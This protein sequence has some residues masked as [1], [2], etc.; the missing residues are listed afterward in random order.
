MNQNEVK[1]LQLVNLMGTN[2]AVELLDLAAIVKGSS[3]PIRSTSARKSTPVKAA[4]L[5]NVDKVRAYAGKRK[6]NVWTLSDC[7]LA[8]GLSKTE[9]TNTLSGP[10]GL[11]SNQEVRRIGRGTYT[12][13]R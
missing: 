6:G 2:R 12:K 5:S 1:F 9:I 7:A 3:A 11:L 10:N 4:S 8:T 13:A